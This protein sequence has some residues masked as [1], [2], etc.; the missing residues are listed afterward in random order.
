MN[1]IGTLRRIHNNKNYYKAAQE[2]IY[3][4]EITYKILI[5]LQIVKFGPI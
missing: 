1:A 5:K 3:G 2:L 4:A